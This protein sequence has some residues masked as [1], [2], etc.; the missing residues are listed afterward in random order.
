MLEDAIENSALSIYKPRLRS[1]HIINLTHRTSGDGHR[2][3]EACIQFQHS[4]TKIRNTRM[5]LQHGLCM[6]SERNTIMVLKAVKGI[7]NSNL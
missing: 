1:L 3:N 2:T 5:P 4:G 6:D 7:K